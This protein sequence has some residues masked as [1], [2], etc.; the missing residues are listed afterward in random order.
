MHVVVSD[1]SLPT[2][3]ETATH[4]NECLHA[5]GIHSATLQPELPVRNRGQAALSAARDA[6]PPGSLPS[7]SSLGVKLSVAASGEARRRA[8]SQGAQSIK[9]ECQLICTRLCE[10][11]M[12][13]KVNRQPVT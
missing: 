3:I 9:D 4:I 12:C 5:Y 10:G 11:L 7:S 1:E 8:A 6:S 2:F 13:C